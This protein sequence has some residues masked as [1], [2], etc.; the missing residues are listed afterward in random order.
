MADK[1]WETLANA[2][3]EAGVSPRVV[4]A[5]RRGYYS[6]F[7]SGSLTPKQDLIETLRAQQIDP[8]LINR[9]VQG[10]F[11]DTEAEAIEW[12][13]SDEGFDVMREIFPS[14]SR[15]KWQKI[16]VKEKK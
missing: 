12:I 13:L 7:R 10:E 5:T 2:M 1:S 11:D 6:E 9:I 16:L 4:R 3:E 8:G 15:E 14:I